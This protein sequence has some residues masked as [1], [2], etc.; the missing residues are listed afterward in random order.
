MYKKLT[1][2]DA[3]NSVKVDIQIAMMMGWKNL[4]VNDF[5]ALVGVSPETGK[6][7][8]APRP[9][10]NT[11]DFQKALSYIACIRH[12]CPVVEGSRTVQIPAEKYATRLDV[13]EALLAAG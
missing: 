9:T 11:E 7:D 3:D 8:N 10:H 13:L 5:G 4:V 1:I 2:I 12:V 6:L